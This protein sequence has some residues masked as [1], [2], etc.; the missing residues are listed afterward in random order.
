MNF[1]VFLII[2][3]I[4]VI[5]QSSFI[6][7]LPKWIGRPD[8]LFILV[9]FAT[10][11]FEW[12]LGLIY[13]F[14]LGWMTDVVSC[15]HLGV[16]PLQNVLVFSILKIVTEGSPLKESAYHV[17]L[18]GVGY[19]LTRMCFF[20]LYTLIM[21]G[22]LSPW[23]WGATLRETS[24]VLLATIPL[25]LLFSAIFEHFSSKRVSYKVRNDSGNQFR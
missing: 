1:F 4:I 21:P 11:K 9:A 13:V 25:F 23:E 22:T 15:I 10:F 19:F 6:P 12:V 7:F 16:F 24:I 18:V 17:P 14:I 8:F 5:I 2:G 3:Y 20:F